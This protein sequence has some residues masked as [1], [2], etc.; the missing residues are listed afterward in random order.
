MEIL[1]IASSTCRSLV[2][3][4][5]EV[6][7]TFAFIVRTGILLLISNTIVARIEEDGVDK[8]KMS[9][10]SVDRSRF[11]TSRFSSFFLYDVMNSV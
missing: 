2:N 8:P 7:N 4:K 9:P 11:G 10:Q 6:L 1:T 5:L 3:A